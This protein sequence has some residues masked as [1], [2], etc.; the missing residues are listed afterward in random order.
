[1]VQRFIAYDTPE[2][3]AFIESFYGGFKEE[4]VW[5]FEFRNFQEADNA[6]SEAFED[7][8]RRRP[9]SSLK[10]L[11]PYEFL[12]KMGVKVNRMRQNVSIGMGQKC[13]QK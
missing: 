7:Y 11:S 2:Q 9:H 10:Y 6:I 12:T 5:P 1:M 8:N 3:N 4:Y 13:L